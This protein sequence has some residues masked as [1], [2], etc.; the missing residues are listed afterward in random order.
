MV[1]Y[2]FESVA[3]YESAGCARIN[4]EAMDFNASY[5]G[6]VL[7]GLHSWKGA[8]NTFA[9]EGAVDIVGNSYWYGVVVV[10]VRFCGTWC[11]NVV[12]GNSGP[13]PTA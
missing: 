8:K 13:R 10:V 11:V 2:V 6:E 12:S 3:A 9:E 1:D 7:E 5:C 4:Y